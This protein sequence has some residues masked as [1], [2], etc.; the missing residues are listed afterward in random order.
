MA[1]KALA[2]FD[3]NTSFE[4]KRS[5][6]WGIDLLLG[7]G[8]VDLKRSIVGGEPKPEIV[9]REKSHWQG[10]DNAYDLQALRYQK[11]DFTARSFDE[12]QQLTKTDQGTQ[13][14][15]LTLSK[16]QVAGAPADTGATPTSTTP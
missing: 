3:A 8:S 4:A 15:P 7:G 11:T 12:F 1:A 10:A 14:Q 9:I 2:R 13:W 16:D 6:F 5:T